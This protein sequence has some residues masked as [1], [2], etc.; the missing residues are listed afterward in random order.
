[1]GTPEDLLSGVDDIFIGSFEA[2]PGTVIPDVSDITLTA[3]KGRE[4]DLAMLYIDIRKSTTLVAGVRRTTAAKM[5]KAFLMGAA[6]LATLNSG[7]IASFNGDGVLMAFAGTARH[8]NAARCAMNLAWFNWYVLKPKLQALF[9]KNKELENFD[10]QFGTGIYEGKVLVV[11]AG[12]KGPNNNDRVWVGN[13]T[14]LAV[15]LSNLGSY[16]YH[17]WVFPD[18]FSSLTPDVLYYGPDQQKMWTWDGADQKMVKT[19]WWLRPAEGMTPS[20]LSILKAYADKPQPLSLIGLLGPP[21]VPW[22]K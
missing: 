8:S 3:N 11:R 15:R 20:I 16:P 9:A 13:P 17:T 2:S 6:R 14:N 5:Y 1:M 21:K 18:I 22:D 7:E 12:I 4:L 19:N 10:F